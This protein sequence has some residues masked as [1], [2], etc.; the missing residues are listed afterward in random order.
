MKKMETKEQILE[1]NLINILDPESLLDYSMLNP[2]PILL[3]KSNFPLPSEPFEVV[4]DQNE[5][6]SQDPHCL[7][8][9]EVP[10]S[11]CERYQERGI[12]SLYDWQ[13][14]CLQLKGV[15]KQGRNLVYSAPT[16]S[17]K[18]LVA[19]LLMLRK[20]L[21]TKKKALFILPFVSVVAEKTLYF[22]DILK[23][24]ELKIQG[25]YANR[26]KIFEEDEIDIFV[27][28]IEKANSLVNRFLEEKKMDQLGIIII[29]EIHMMSD[30]DRGYLL[31]LLVT[32]ILYH[33][34][35]SFQIVGLSA[36][37]PNIENFQRWLNAA[38]Y[39]THYRPVPLIEYIKIE[40]K[41]YDKSF[42]IVRELIPQKYSF[43]DKDPEMIGLL[44]HEIVNENHS[45]LLFC[46]T[47]KVC[48]S[49][50]LRLSEILDESQGKLFLLFRID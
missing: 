36:T 1:E 44:I 3:P 48:E 42:Q 12:I 14:E 27:A 13:V 32:K 33:S 2:L 16:S 37:L 18:T 31:E 29:D 20:V 9:W 45:V 39:I 34:S 26:G 19:E 40:N 21:Q 47:K 22:Q 11:V 8:Y 38:L 50:A 25:K 46:A 43:I 41:L 10:S 23:P 5:E 28:T 24:L 6:I 49:E 17:G 35:L 7:S 15:W 4:P 30:R